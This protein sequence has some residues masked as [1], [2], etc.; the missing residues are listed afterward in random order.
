MNS[1]SPPFTFQSKTLQSQVEQEQSKKSFLQSE[2]G[3]Q[4]SETAHLRAREEQLSHEV[5]TLREAK[6]HIEEEYHKLKTKRSV[7]DLQMKELQDQLETEQYFS[8][9]IAHF[10]CNV[11]LYLILKGGGAVQKQF[12]CLKDGIL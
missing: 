10:T 12:I 3:V 11:L 9:S 7:D 1:I 5:A 4:T 8:V 2:L 6:R